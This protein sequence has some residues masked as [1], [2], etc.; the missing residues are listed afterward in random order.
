MKNKQET[1][2]E[3][4]TRLI[5]EEGLTRDQAREYIMERSYHRCSHEEAIERAKNSP[6]AK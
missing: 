5:Q 2:E 3:M 6:W 1:K 4:I